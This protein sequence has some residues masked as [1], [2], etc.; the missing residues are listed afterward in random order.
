MG[1]EGIFPGRIT[2]IYNIIKKLREDWPRVLKVWE[3]KKNRI[4][5]VGMGDKDRG[6][7]TKIK[8]L[9]ESCTEIH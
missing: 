1:E 7:M 6:W 9:L 2:S 5:G 4:R 3:Q 8:V